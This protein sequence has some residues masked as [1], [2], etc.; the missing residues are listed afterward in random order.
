MSGTTAPQGWSIAF[1]LSM[2]CRSMPRNADV[3]VNF[4]EYWEMG[5]GQGPTLQL[6]DGPAG[7]QAQRLSPHAGWAGPV[8]DRK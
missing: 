2:T 3:R 6:G 7:E 5:A 1:A 4:I 8:E